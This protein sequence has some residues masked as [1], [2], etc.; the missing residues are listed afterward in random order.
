MSPPIAIVIP[1]RNALPFATR[2]IEGISKQTLQPD[3]VVVMD[4]E[5]SDN[6]PELYRTAGYTVMPVAAASFDHGGTRNFSLAFCDTE[7]V[8]FLTQDAILERPD[9]LERLC[10]PFDDPQVA[11]VSGRQVARPVAGAIERHARL[12][13][14]PASSSRRV[15]PEAENLGIRA[16]FN[17]NSFAAYRRQALLAIGG[18][19][20]RVIMC[21]D[22]IAAARALLA[23]WT[24]VYA[25]DA[26]VQHSH[27]YSLWAEFRR[28]FD[29]G[30]FHQ[31]NQDMLRPFRAPN[32]EGRRFVRSEMHYLAQ[33]A[34]FRI[35]EA[36]L[37]TGLKLLGYQIGRKEAL[38]PRA[39][40]RHLAMQTAFF[41][42]QGVS[43]NA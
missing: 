29:I 4:S 36:T 7:I 21:E 39:V 24:V 43:K 16:I 3:S 11:I 2:Q 15:W 13:N 40:K 41:N 9:A 8:V 17:S 27:G 14:Y 19:P 6:A 18:F 25:G 22:Q 10:V 1:I 23:G 35:P 32:A 33:H 28:Y 20:E 37:R 26:I 12:F 5:S 31:Q 34:P 30:V 38:L 42:A